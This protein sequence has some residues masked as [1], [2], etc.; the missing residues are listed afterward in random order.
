[1][2]HESRLKRMIGWIVLFPAVGVVWCRHL[3]V[4]EES[5]AVGAMLVS[6]AR[7]AA[8]VR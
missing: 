1:M 4:S 6:W 3:V 5:S 8:S 2:G 7:K